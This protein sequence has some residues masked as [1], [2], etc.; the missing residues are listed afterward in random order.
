M[1][2]AQGCRPKSAAPSITLRL[3]FAFPFAL[4]LVGFGTRSCVIVEADLNCVTSLRWP[5]TR[6]PPTWSSQAVRLI[7]GDIGWA[8]ISFPAGTQGK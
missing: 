3:S 8:R 5:Q 7:T 4:S 2:S 1:V 6:D